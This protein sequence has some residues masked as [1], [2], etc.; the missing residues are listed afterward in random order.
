M[1]WTVTIT[2]L[3]PEHTAQMRYNFSSPH[4][5]PPQQISCKLWLSAAVCQPDPADAQH[6]CG[7][8]QSVYIK[9]RGEKFTS[10]IR[11]INTILILHHYIWCMD[12]HCWAGKNISLDSICSLEEYIQHLLFVQVVI[13]GKQK[14]TWYVSSLMRLSYLRIP[15]TASLLFFCSDSTSFSSSLTW[16]H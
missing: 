3:D 5:R 13:M 8:P 9:G 14:L 7:P 6:S 1:L 4:L 2:L 15:F 12:M 10:S 11:S 16:K